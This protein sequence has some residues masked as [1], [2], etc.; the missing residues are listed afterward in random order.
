MNKHA[1]KFILILFSIA[2]FSST[3]FSEQEKTL[4]R[5]PSLNSD[6]TKIAFSFQGDIW[7]MPT[8]GNK[9]ERLTIHEGYESSPLW[10]SD[11]STIAF[12]SNRYGNDD[13]FTIP[14]SGGIPK[15]ITYHSANDNL[16][17]FS[18]DGSL[19]FTTARN[20]QH[21]EWDSEL[22]TISS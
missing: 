9:A 15:R 1:Q 16:T 14:V 11:N 7:T 22:Q 18:K 13:I 2:F 20:F 17:D 8:N 19:L 6:G 12:S 4:V 3:A 5:F 10:S 21:V